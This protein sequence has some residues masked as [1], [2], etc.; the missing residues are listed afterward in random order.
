V[1]ERC[2]GQVRGGM[3]GIY[4]LDFGACLSLGAALGADLEMLAALLP[5]IEPLIV[6]AWR[7]GEQDS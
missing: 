6:K 2:R 4:A 3:G 5:H 7:A 1:I